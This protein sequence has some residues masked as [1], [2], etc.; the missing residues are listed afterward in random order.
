MK[1]I[2]RTL[3]IAGIA[4]ATG[5]GAANADKVRF[6]VAAEPYAPF[7]SQD[8]SGKWVGWEIDFMDAICKEA[9]LDCELVA[10]AWDGI[11]PALT[12][13]KID[14]IWSSMSITAEREK[15]I[16]FTDPY[17]KNPLSV[18]GDKNQKFD[19]SPEGLKG[20]VLG[21]QVSTTQADYADKYFK[22]VVKE[23]K[24]YQTQD[25]VNQD[26]LSGR[27]DA[28]IA[29]KFPLAEF[30][31]S[32]EATACCDMKGDVFYDEAIIGRGTGAGV[33][34]DDNELREKINAAIKVLRDNGEYKKITD[35]YFAIRHL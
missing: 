34:K 23:I 9:K 20:K 31:K 18:I 21:L 4:L 30:L 33:R 22:S 35:K 16:S 17:Y 28:Q 32:P 3:V 13:K 12:S 26:L 15:T 5:A 1:K 10:T 24:S 29:D 27:I 7:S 2:W 11:I 6:G 19:A 8:A 25:E 14:L